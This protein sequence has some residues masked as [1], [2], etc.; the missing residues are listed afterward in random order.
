MARTVYRG[1]F[2]PL[3]ALVALVTGLGLPLALPA[4]AAHDG[5]AAVLGPARGAELHVMSYNLR[6]ASDAGPHSWQRRRPV[7]AELLRRE[8][9]TVLG[10]QEGLYRQLTDIERDLPAY[11]DWI[12]QGRGGGHRDE[13]VAVFF[14]TRRLAPLAS[15]HFWLSGTPAVPGSRSWGN[16]A[17]RMATWVRFADRR[18]GGEFVVLNTHLDNASANAR[19]R[20]AELVRDRIDAFPPALPVILTGDFNIPAETSPQYEVLTRG[21]G[22]TDTWTT[23]TRRATPQTGTFHGFGALLPDG[24]R[25]DWIL[26]R[27]ATTVRTAAINTFAEDGEY[28]SDHLPAQAVLTLAA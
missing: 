7:L 16:K 28:A 8:Q 13:F 11:Y 23:A 2:R 27:A 26:T 25:I 3:G 9:P 18:T 20:G 6:Y 21:A 15:G 22:L 24:P 10:T 5:A 17:I 4:A 14:D 1:L 19:Q 12:G